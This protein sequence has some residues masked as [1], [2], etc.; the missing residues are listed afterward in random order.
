MA[1]F[2]SS[3]IGVL[4]RTLGGKSCGLQTLSSSSSSGM[5]TSNLCSVVRCFT[6]SSGSEK[7]PKRPLSAYI[8]YV[9]ETQP[10]FKK[11][12]PDLRFVDLTRHIA[13]SWKTLPE[14]EKQGYEVAAEKARQAYKEELFQYKAQLSGAQ[15]DAMYEAK[16]QRRAKLKKMRKKRELTVLGKPKRPRSAFNI[17]LAEHFQ[18]ATGSHV[19][20]KLKSMY[21]DWS[22]LDASQKKP[23]VQLAE[24]DKIRYEHEMNSWEEHMIELGREDLIRFENRMK[25]KRARNPRKRKNYVSKASKAASSGSDSTSPLS[26][27]AD[28]VSRRHTVEE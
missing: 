4:L 1:T 15:I 19:S 13:Q 27:K 7:P 25:L 2:L 20:V 26:S 21:D 18:D 9:Q 3:G 14:S 17:F 22:K 5:I 10:V 6:Q 24:D 23:Y 11:Q 12:H 16:R 8:R 28:Q